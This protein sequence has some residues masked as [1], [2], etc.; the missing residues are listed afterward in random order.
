MLWSRACVALLF[1][2]ATLSVSQGEQLIDDLAL[3]EPG[4]TEQGSLTDWLWED[5]G[6]DVLGVGSPNMFSPE[7]EPGLDWAGFSGPDMTGYDLF[8]TDQLGAIEVPSI[9]TDLD[10]M[11]LNHGF[12]S[13]AE[14]SVD[15][16]DMLYK[17]QSCSVDLSRVKGRDPG[18]CPKFMNNIRIIT[19]C[20]ENAV[21]YDPQTYPSFSPCVLC[22]CDGFYLVLNF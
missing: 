8:T 2:F 18:I 7:A 13:E 12:T 15:D 4:F 14:C 9:Q 1:P 22:K 16:G 17:R 11:S 10:L 5:T 19:C 20:C 6:D 3:L 21:E